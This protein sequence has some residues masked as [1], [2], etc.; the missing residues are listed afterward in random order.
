MA[1]LANLQNR[2]NGRRTFLIGL[3]IALAAGI[4]GWAFLPGRENVDVVNGVPPVSRSMV[5]ISETLATLAT[6]PPAERGAYLERTW[7]H[8]AE[9][10]VYFVRR[11]GKVP[12]GA[13]VQRVEFYYG[14]LEGV[15][16]ESANGDRHG[17]FNN[18]LVALVSVEGVEKPV[19]VIV[20]CLNG[21]F[22]LEEDLR[23]LQPIG[24]HTPIEQFVI[25][26]REGLVHHVDFPTA[27]AIAE[28][29]NLP[30]YRGQTI[31]SRTRLTPA[32]ARLLESQTD[33]LQV[34]VLVYEG[35]R[36]DLARGT[37]APASGG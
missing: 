34:T 25:G 10:V 17:Y 22:A 1:I 31:T 18:Q 12:A 35:D 32:Q 6:L 14:S 13:R 29:H 26:P 7:P 3:G 15:S 9:D 36:F 27:I 37:Y 4:A 16:A 19:K 11:Q 20:Q 24:S 23:R 5:S 8:L 30:L 2:P 33:R 28:Q 21:T